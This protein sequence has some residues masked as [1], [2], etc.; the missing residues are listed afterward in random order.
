MQLPIIPTAGVFQSVVKFHD[1]ARSPLRTVNEY[2]LELYLEDG[3]F[4]Y[5]N[6]VEYPMRRGNFLVA[7]P[8]D[9]RRSSLPFSCRFIRLQPDDALSPLLRELGGVTVMDDLSA[10]EKSF[11]HVAEW[12]LSDDPYNR[13]AAGAEVLTLLRMVHRQQSR[14]QAEGDQND[15]LTRALRCIEQMYMR[16]LTVEDIARDCHVSPSYLHRLF[17]ARMGATPHAVLM[18]RRITAAKTLLVN[19]EEV[20]ADIAWKCGFHSPSYFS[21]CFRRQVGQSPRDFRK[22]MSYQL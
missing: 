6:G 3:G 12:F 9:Q 14:L 1:I 11:R 4:T 19:S 13:L 10:C 18:R 22:S 8:G 15:V 5:L 7:C 16:P 2:E 17:M 20:L 21:D